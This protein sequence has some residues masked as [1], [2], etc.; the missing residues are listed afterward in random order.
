MPDPQQEGGRRGLHLL[1]YGNFD[2]LEAWLVKEVA[3][4]CTYCP[5]DWRDLWASFVANSGLEV[6]AA[7]SLV[8][9]GIG[10]PYRSD[11]IENPT[12]LEI[13][14]AVRKMTANCPEADVIVVTGSGA[15]TVAITE[16]LRAIASTQPTDTALFSVIAGRLGVDIPLT[17]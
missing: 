10:R 11:D 9:R 13:C 8:N 1:D 2:I 7:A 15:R 12:P 6:A 16:E 17:L 5:D 3:L 4:A 14:D